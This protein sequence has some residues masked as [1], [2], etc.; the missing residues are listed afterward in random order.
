M[1]SDRQGLKISLSFLGSYL[2]MCF[3]KT[4]KYTK[5]EEDIDQKKE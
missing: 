5:K 4:R 2:K 3:H 1:S